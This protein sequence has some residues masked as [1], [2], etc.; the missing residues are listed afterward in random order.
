MENKNMKVTLE[1]IG[2]VTTFNVLSKSIVKVAKDIDLTKMSDNGLFRLAKM[3]KLQYNAVA[4][5]CETQGRKPQYVGGDKMHITLK[6]TLEELHERTVI[7][8]LNRAVYSM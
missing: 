4:E 6:S 1:V 5:F 2:D 3:T 8:L 7:E